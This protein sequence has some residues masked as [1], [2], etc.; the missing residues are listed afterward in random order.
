M[1]GQ[2]LEI[3]VDTL[4]FPPVKRDFYSSDFWY[5]NQNALW[6][7][8]YLN[9]SLHGSIF[10]IYFMYTF[11]IHFI[12]FI[13]NSVWFPLISFILANVVS[14]WML[15]SF[16]DISGACGTQKK[17]NFLLLDFWEN[18]FIIWII[19]SGAFKGI[20]ITWF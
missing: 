11:L 16:C 20:W 13:Q 10:I 4:N 19:C 2:W 8:L 7:D 3:I 12:I 5:L 17:K 6:R 1:G 15:I 9:L 18:I 14:W